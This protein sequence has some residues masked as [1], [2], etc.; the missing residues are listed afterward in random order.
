MK[1]YFVT[2]LSVALLLL[3]IG[4]NQTPPDTP[5]N[6]T[7]N[8]TENSTVNTTEKSPCASSRGKGK[9]TILKY[10]RILCS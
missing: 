7:K 4:C 5:D 9:A 6:T 1:K 3:L 8:S 2:L 10:I